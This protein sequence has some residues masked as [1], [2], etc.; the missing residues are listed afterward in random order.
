M[1]YHIWTIGCQMNEADSRHLASQLESLG[2]TATDRAEEADLVVLNTCVVRQQ[3]ED[4]AL[5]R[6]QFMHGL[7]RRNPRLRIAAMGCLV[8]AREGTA[9]P[10]R[11]RLD[12]VDFFLPPSDPS[13]LIRVLAEELGLGPARA[14]DV[15]DGEPDAF[16]LP[17]PARGAVIAHVP[18]VLGCS[19]ACT[20][21]V[22]P[23]RRGREHSRPM[24]EVLA[25]LRRLAGQGVREVMVLGQIIDRYGLDRPGEGDLADLLRRAAAVPG[26]LRV[27]FMTSHPGYFTD[28]I[29]EAVAETPH[30]MPHFELPVQAG[31]DRVLEA[32][33]RGYTRDDYRR[34][35]DR[36]RAR[37]PEAALH[38]DIIVGFPG[39]TET[40]F[41]DTCRLLEELRLDKVHLARYSP[42]PQTYAARH[43]PDDVPPA[44]KERRLHAL[45]ELQ[46][47]LQGAGNA[48]LVGRT[49]EVLVEGRDDRRGRWRGRTPQDKLVFFADAANQ[50]GQLVSVRITHAGPYSMV[51]E[52]ATAGAG[53]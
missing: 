50:L 16:S 2:L 13:P 28:R 6:L 11:E 41:Q 15:S 33:R 43:L 42:R 9:R 34:L 40:E 18:A 53:R 35:V 24:D 14:G 4:K 48:A 38:T 12:F 10:L 27:R 47:R 1:T 29:L 26:L 20:Y 32:M 23:Y 52:P 5:A 37:L 31:S 7:K 46:Y 17:A 51:G 19:H 21:C 36:I 49:V 8:G 3:A 30:V 39:E 44:E 25:E 45:N 22:I